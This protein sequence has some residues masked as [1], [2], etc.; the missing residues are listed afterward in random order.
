MNKTMKP[1]TVVWLFVA[2][3]LAIFSAAAWAQGVTNAADAVTNVVA[4]AGAGG[5]GDGLVPGV[6]KGLEYFIPFL[7]PMCVAYV[8]KILPGLSP[9]LLPFAA[10]AIGSASDM[11][12]NSIG[13]VQHSNPA[14]AAILGA[15]GIGIREVHDQTFRAAG[16][17]GPAGPAESAGTAPD[18]AKTLGL[19]LLAGVVLLATGCAHLDIS[20]ARYDPE[21]KTWVFDRARATFFANKE[22][23]Q[24][25]DLCVRTKSVTQLVRASGLQSLPDPQTIDAIGSAA[26]KI[27]GEAVKAAMGIPPVPLPSE[28]PALLNLH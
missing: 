2:I 25:L 13:L 10:V 27:A 4:P 1:R 12:L 18:V 23:A 26:G 17:A 24:K 5:T 15:A 7:V 22:L 9:R 20:S 6:P 19:A 8:K 28:L 16:P 11:L 14:L 21:T 3:A